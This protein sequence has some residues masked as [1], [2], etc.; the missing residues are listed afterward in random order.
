[1]RPLT[2]VALSVVL[3]LVALTACTTTS[4][5]ADPPAGTTSETF[6]PSQVRMLPDN[7][8]QAPS[9]PTAAIPRR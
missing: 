7:P 4:V 5:A 3:A 6:D 9:A 2:P 8:L 1:M